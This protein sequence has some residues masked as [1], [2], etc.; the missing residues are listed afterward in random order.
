VGYRALHSS[1]IFLSRVDNDLDIARTLARRSCGDL[2]DTAIREIGIERRGNNIWIVLAAAFD[3]PALKN[4]DDVSER[5]LDL[6]NE[7]RSHSRRCGSKSFPPA[8]PLLLSAKLNGAAR[9]HARD[10]AKHGQFAH[11]G[12]DGS[13]PM[14]R[15]TREGYAWRTVG[16]NIA[17]GATSSEEVMAG[18][19]ASPGHCEN[20]MD[21]RF[22]QMG[23]AYTLDSR[24][25]FGV[26][27][28][29]VFAAPR[30]TPDRPLP[31]RGR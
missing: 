26:Y 22:T 4:A 3:A 6:T 7:A 23:I 15:V 27:W 5:V 25:K 30:E 2:T 28:T 14:E 11:Q 20:L 29:Q 16:E 18:W 21:P 9:E 12:S 31:K 13:T 24:S 8:P 10:M 1:S 19:L 17:A